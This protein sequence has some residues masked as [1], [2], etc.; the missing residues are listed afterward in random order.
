[1]RSTPQAW[2]PA[3]AIGLIAAAGPAHAQ[4]LRLAGQ[5]EL[6]GGESE[7]QR[8]PKD[9]LNGVVRITADTITSYDRDNKEL[10]VAKYKIDR[11]REPW[12]IAMTTAGGPNAERGP[13]SATGILKLTEGTLTLCYAPEGKDPPKEFATRPGTGQNLFV[14]KK[15]E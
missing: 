2:I 11:S 9:R 6:T 10:Y 15:T 14:L 8:I 7:G 13:K 1:M 5:Y 12:S 3:L 4:D